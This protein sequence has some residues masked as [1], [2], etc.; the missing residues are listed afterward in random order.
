[1]PSDCAVWPSLEHSDFDGGPG[2]NWQHF[3]CDGKFLGNMA[4][5]VL[6]LTHALRVSYP[7]QAI[8][9]ASKCIIASGSG[10]KCPR[11]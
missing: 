4:S 2:E 9:A 1:M 6:L 5:E 3:L 11:R 10:C 7:A 8:L